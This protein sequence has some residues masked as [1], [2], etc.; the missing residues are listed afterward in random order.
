MPFLVHSKLVGPTSFPKHEEAGWHELKRGVVRTRQV[1]SLFSSFVSIVLF[2]LRPLPFL[3][4]MD[5]DAEYVLSLA[6]QNQSASSDASGRMG[7]IRRGQRG[8]SRCRYLVLDREAD[9]SGVWFRQPIVQS[10]ILED[11]I[12]TETPPLEKPKP[13]D[14]IQFVHD[15]STMPCPSSFCC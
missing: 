11:V 8:R 4:Q 6:T 7:T 9:R 5:A 13:I 14:A 2:L 15:G 10:P 1:Y 12:S 3:S